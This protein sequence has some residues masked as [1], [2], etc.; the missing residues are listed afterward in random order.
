M[1]RRD[2]RGDFRR[3]LTGSRLIGDLERSLGFR[4]FHR[5]KGSPRRATLE[6][7]NSHEKKPSA[8]SSASRPC[9]ASPTTFRAARSGIRRTAC[10]PALATGVRANVIRDILAAY[11]AIR[12]DRQSRSSTTVRRGLRP[13]RST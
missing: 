7:E 5:A 8:R 13:S 12:V 2:G 6:A 9:P 11:P 1:T 3:N 10:L 4:L